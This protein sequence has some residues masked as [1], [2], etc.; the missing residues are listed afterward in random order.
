[1]GSEDMFFS[2]M[3]GVRVRGFH[4]VG[5]QGLNYSSRLGSFL[6]CVSVLFS[7][8]VLGVLIGGVRVSKG[9]FRV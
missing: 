5:F 2:L 3:V 1:M 8:S 6:G 7:G 4:N 9:C